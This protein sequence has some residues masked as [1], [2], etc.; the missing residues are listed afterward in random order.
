VTVIVLSVTA[1]TVGAIV[2]AAGI[3][4]VVYVVVAEAAPEPMALDAVTV[5]V[6]EVP[7]LSPLISLEVAVIPFMEESPV[8]DT[9]EQPGPEQ[10]LTS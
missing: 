10:Y 7:D 9:G 1:V 3:A 6:Y 5:N 8:I 4:N 2:G